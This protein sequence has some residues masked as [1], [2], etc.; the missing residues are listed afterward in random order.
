M[1]LPACVFIRDISGLARCFEMR[2]QPLHRSL[3]GSVVLPKQRSRYRPCAGAVSFVQVATLVIGQR[4]DFVATPSGMALLRGKQVEIVCRTDHCRHDIRGLERSNEFDDF[5]DVVVVGKRKEEQPHMRGLAGEP[6]AG[7]RHDSVI[8]LREQSVE[9][10]PEAVLRHM[11]V[12][13]VGGV[14]PAV[15]GADQIAVAEHDLDPADIVEVVA[16]GPTTAALVQR[17]TQHAAVGRAGRRRHHQRPAAPLQFGVEAIESHARFQ[18]TESEIV[19]DLSNAVHALAKIDYDLTATHRRTRTESQVSPHTDRKQRHQKF[20]CEANDRLHRVG[21]IGEQHGAGHVVD[22]RQ[23]MPSICGANLDICRSGGGAKR[24]G[25][26]LNKARD[27]GGG[28]VHG[29]GLI[30]VRSW[31]GSEVLKSKP[32]RFRP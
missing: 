18:Y 20:V 26:R 25:D 28:F 5:R 13:M 22:I 17:V 9:R 29:Y 12:W 16:C 27:G 4:A 7:A 11:P 23:C 14:Q 2:A 15:A 21:G 8:R 24:F 3:C 10:R 6:D 1:R 30:H 32:R 31:A 19:I